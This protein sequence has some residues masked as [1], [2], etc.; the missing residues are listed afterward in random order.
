MS[1]GVPIPRSRGSLTGFIL[2]VL[3]AW[4]ALAPFVGPAF[5]FGFTPDTIWHYTQGRLYL[6]L[7]PGGAV[8][9]MGLIIMA[10]RSRWLGGL[11]GVI[12]ALAGAW[13]I[14]GAALI[15]LLPAS[16]GVGS[17]TAGTP[18]GT[19]LTRITLTDL[20]FFTGVGAAIVFFAA[21]AVGRFSMVAHDD[22][23]RAEQLADA[24]AA[25]AGRSVEGGLA[26]IYGSDRESAPT[27][28]Y[29]AEPNQY[30]PGQSQYP[31]QYPPDLDSIQLLPGHGQYQPPPDPD[32]TTQQQYP[33]TQTYPNQPPYPPG[34]R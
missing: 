23:V 18:I 1:N 19:S 29:Q 9:L 15:K 31:S 25:R 32:S 12:A 10:T 16:L 6:S 14:A 13:F 33:Q 7:L 24:T 3:G 27:E 5:K 28:P 2:V 30:V 26:L 20:A 34:Q 11:C 17:V 8:L 21:L 22:Y 4:G